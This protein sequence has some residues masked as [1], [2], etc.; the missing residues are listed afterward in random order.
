MIL[1]DLFIGDE[2]ST[3]MVGKIKGVSLPKIQDRV[4]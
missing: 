4:I 2:K 1:A 3:R